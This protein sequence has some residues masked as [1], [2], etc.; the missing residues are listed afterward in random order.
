MLKRA[1]P[2][3]MLETSS[4]LTSMYVGGTGIWWRSG[5][6]ASISQ[7]EQGEQEAAMETLNIAITTLTVFDTTQAT[8][9]PIASELINQL[10]KRKGKFPQTI[11]ELKKY[12][13]AL[14]KRVVSANA[15]DVD[16]IIDNAKTLKKRIGEFLIVKLQ[17]S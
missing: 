14:T 15:D 3:R 12:N 17:H 8:V 6:T 1:D 16:D 5:I 7:M 9:S 4:S 13:E 10:V 2:I 11:S